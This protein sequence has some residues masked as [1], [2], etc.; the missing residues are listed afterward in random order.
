MKK[1]IGISALL[2]FISCAP[3]RFIIPLKQGEH[4]V[5]F[6]LGG[7]LIDYKGIIIPTP[8]TSVYYGYGFDSN[9][10]FYAGL[11]TTSLAFGNFQTDFGA[12]FNLL[13]QKRWTPGLSVTPCINFILNP[14]W[15]DVRLWPQLDANIYWAYTKHKHYAY[16][17]ISNWFELSYSRAHNQPIED[18][19][20][21]NPQ[22]GHV[23]KIKSLNIGLELKFLAPSH[24]NT[25]AFVPYK[26]LTGQYGANGI[27][28]Y[29]AKRF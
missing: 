29:I 21:I 7:H 10:T 26:S 17:G 12:V 2:L 24:I 20:F 25:Y 18:Y 6:N 3:A 11:H 4:A 9:F 8:M 28:F 1:Y 23:F 22:I 19:W 13:Q 15:G 27:Y 5:G 14:K 16:L